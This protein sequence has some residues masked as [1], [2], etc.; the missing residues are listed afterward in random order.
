MKLF[1]AILLGFSPFAVTA[2][3]SA[4][5]SNFPSR[6]IRLIVGMAP[7]GGLDTGA[8]L[9]AARMS[10]LLGQSVVVEN[11]PGAGTTMGAALVAQSKPD[12][13]TLFFSGT[14]MLIAPAVYKKLP[15]DTQTAF[16]PIGGVSWSQMVLVAHPSVP[17]NDLKGLVA[18][19]KKNPSAYSY[20]SPGVGTPHHLVMERLG[21]HTGARVVHIPYKGAGPLMQDLVTGRVQIA[22]VSSTAAEPQVKAGALK[23]IAVTRSVQTPG[24]SNWPAIARDFPGFDAYSSSFIVAPAGVPPPVLNKLSKALEGALSSAGLQEEMMAT[25]AVVEYKS[26]AALTKQIT[27][28]ILQWSAIAKESGVSHDDK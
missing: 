25:G 6:P 16:V 14:S 3:D 28:E 9:V 4:A 21:K 19:I 5:E 8:R 1:L 11:R 22:M 13:Y 23:A 10:T 2:S 26:P 20:G 7:G 27:D 24:M 15:Y 17:T 12:G 18:E